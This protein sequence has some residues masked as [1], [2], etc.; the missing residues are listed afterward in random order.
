MPREQ[1]LYFRNAFEM[2]PMG[3]VYLGT[4]GEILQVNRRFLRLLGYDPEELV[5]RPLQE[6][7]HPDDRDVDL[8]AVAL[9]SAG[10][11]ARYRINK[12]FIHKNGSVLWCDFAVSA[13]N[14]PEGGAPSFICILEDDSYRKMEMDALQDALAEKEAVCRE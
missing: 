1:D 11:M 14:A 4:E 7:T 13:G 9:V 6:I 2:A 5:G 12:R 3:M 10:D 8:V